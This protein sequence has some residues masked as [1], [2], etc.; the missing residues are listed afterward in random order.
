MD[1]SI[2]FQTDDIILEG[3]LNRQSPDCAAIITHPHPLYG[4]DMDNGVVMVVAEA[5]ARKGW[6]TL[7]FNFRGTGGSKGQ[8]DDGV[9]EQADLQAAIDHLRDLGY[10]RIDLSGYSFGAWVVTCWSRAH[11][12][13]N[14]RVYLVAPPVAFIDFNVQMP[15]PQLVHA[16]TGDL[17]DLAPSG[18]IA[19][20][21]PHW[22]PAARLDVIRGADHSFWGHFQALQNAVAKAIDT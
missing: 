1:E 9:G 6:S 14:H 21:L 16:F 4:G 5:Y 17:D 13:H 22:H 10:S 19:T 20:A 8:F 3:R 11:P 18:R 7:R 2:T 12:H 15:I